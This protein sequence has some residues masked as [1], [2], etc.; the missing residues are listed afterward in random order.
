MPSF[1]RYS[2][3]ALNTF[4]KTNMYFETDPFLRYQ[5]P[6]YIGFKLFFL[7]DQ[8]NAGLLSTT[9]LKNTA[10]GY[11]E[12]IGDTERMDYLKSFVDL[13]QKINS[14]TPWFF[15]QIDGLDEAWK[16]MYQEKEYKPIL[17]DRKI[18]INCLDESIDLRMTALMDL[19]RK[20]CFDWP[21][22]REVVPKNLRRFKVRIYCYEGRSLNRWGLPWS[23]AALGLKGAVEAAVPPILKQGKMEMDKWFGSDENGGFG[24]NK[25]GAID[26]KAAISSMFS[27]KDDSVNDNISRVMFD[28]NYCEW[29]PDE[30]NALFSGISNKEF[31]LKA[32]KIAFSY[33]NVE[34]DNIFRFFHGKKV[35]DF[36]IQTLDGLALDK[37]KFL[38]GVPG[39]LT[40]YLN[41][42]IAQLATTLKNK[43]TGG[44]N[45]L[46]M[47]N[48]YGFQPLLNAMAIANGGLTGVVSA[49]KEI[50]KNASKKN[51]SH[52]TNKKAVGF[53]EKGASLINMKG[54]Q[55]AKTQGSSPENKSLTNDNGLDANK[56]NPFSP[57]NIYFDDFQGS[58]TNK[59]K[60]ATLVIPE[61]PYP[62]SQSLINDNGPDATSQ[63]ASPENV[64]LTNDNGPDATTQ[65]SSP[66]IS[67]T[68]ATKDGSTPIPDNPY[69][70]SPSLKNDDGPDATSQGASPENISLTND[71][72]PDATSQGASPQI[73][74]SNDN[75]PD[76][77]GQGP[78]PQISQTNVSGKPSG[79]AYK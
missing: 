62:G 6:T 74:L 66:Q 26:A 10:M 48:V 69:P 34:E 58:L 35:S 76:A 9:G 17:S 53:Q 54:S 52:D 51:D 22:R 38:D 11:L 47:G 33:E 41:G 31:G 16:H 75:G 57:K 15:Q 67:L 21:N 37:P 39:Y 70:G 12:N 65:G 73:S 27:R 1:T 18:V 50:G 43:L 5:D 20:A 79:N 63:G 59:S 55:S 49:A 19:Y 78:S 72:G 68:N 32:Q 77:K 40:P 4:K 2:D 29:L 13:L 23:P 44:L 30:T 61:N 64:S 45:D 46:L 71:N 25:D 24:L 28:F 60:D 7:F 14:V 56:P 36:I 8:P 3:S 42:A